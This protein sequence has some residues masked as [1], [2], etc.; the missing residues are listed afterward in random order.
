M[1]SAAATDMTR[2]VVPVRFL[3][4]VPHGAFCAFHIPRQDPDDLMM[5]AM[6]AAIPWARPINNS[7]YGLPCL[8]YLAL[9][10]TVA[11]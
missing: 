4:Q 3:R 6:N 5:S 9:L 11:A 2:Q 7:T 1:L 8:V 10:L